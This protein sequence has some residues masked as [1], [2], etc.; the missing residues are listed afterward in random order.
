MSSPPPGTIVHHPIR[1]GLMHRSCG[2]NL[3]FGARR[4]CTERGADVLRS[5]LKQ[6]FATASVND[7]VQG[8]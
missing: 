3:V 2:I 4:T 6:L 1:D 8:P 7:V 5:D